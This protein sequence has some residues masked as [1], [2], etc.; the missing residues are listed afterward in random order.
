[1]NHINQFN[2]IKWH[3]AIL[4][5]TELIHE[6]GWNIVIKLYAYNK[7]DNKRKSTILVFTDVDN[8]V[9][10]VDT[11]ELTDNASA[12]NVNDAYIKEKTQQYQVFFYLI[13]GYIHFS[14][15]HLKIERLE[16]FI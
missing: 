1:M 5:K 3:D 11:H 9:M 12:G 8:L 6:K 10:S 13:D 16:H 7:A 4:Q 14:F 2:A 15:K